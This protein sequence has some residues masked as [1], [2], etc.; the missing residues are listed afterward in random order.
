MVFYSCC[1]N[2]I[3]FAECKNIV[4]YRMFRDRSADEI[5]RFWYDE[6]GCFP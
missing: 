2:L 4:P 1:L 5:P 6:Q 3:H